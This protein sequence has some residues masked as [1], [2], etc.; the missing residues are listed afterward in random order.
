MTTPSSTIYVRPG[1]ASATWNYTNV[2]L[3]TGGGGAAV[4]AVA[5]DAS[6]L[7]N[8][9]FSRGDIQYSL[10]NGATWLTYALP[11]D[12]QGAYVNVAGTVWRFLD[13]VG[14]D[15]DRPD[16]FNVD[17]KLTNNSIVTVETTVFMDTQP[18]GVVGSNDV[19]FTTM[20]AG[21]VVDT[22]LPIDVGAT[23]GGRWVIDGQSQ[24][25]L[26]AIAY[27]PAIDAPAKLVI[28]NAAWMPAD[29]GAASVTVHYYDRYQIDSN[30]NPV[31]GTGAARTLT[32]AVEAGAGGSLPGFAAEARLGAAVDAVSGQPTLTALSGGGFVAV[33]Q[34]PD[35]VAGGAG[36]GLWAQLRDAG[37]NTL[38]AAFAITPDGDARIE[39]EPAVSALAGGRFVV[40]Y[41]VASGAAT[42]VAYRVIE[43]NGTAGAERVV[44]TG[45]AGDAAMPTLAT[46]ADGSF[47]VGWRSGAAVHVQAVDAAG[48]PAGAQQVYGALGS[49]YSP[50]LA[51]L[52][53]GGYI[54][55]WGEINDGNVYA[56]T[57]RAPAAVF[58]ASGDGY[59]ASITTAAPLPHV[60]A[61]AGGGFVVAWDSYANDPRGFSISDIFFQ[62]YDA[63]G[64]AVGAVVQANVDSGGGRFDA[65]VTALSSGGFLV[66][67]QGNDDDG[68]G[69]YG[70]RFGADGTALDS[71]EF[72][73]NGLRAGDQSSPDVI[74]LAGGGFAGAWVE[75]SASGAVS[76]EARVLPGVA[77]ASAV[78]GAQSASVGHAVDG[79]GSALTSGAADTGAAS[80]GVAADAAHTSGG[81]VT[82][83]GATP[84]TTTSGAAAVGAG[85]VAGSAAGS[86]SSS[87]ASSHVALP[88]KTI[89]FGSDGHALAAVGG[90]SK[91]VGSA[92]LDTL[93]YAGAR[94]G[95]HIAE[96]GGGT[97]AVTDAG[98]NHALLSG[99]ERLHFSDG[100][101]ALDID[102]AAGQAYR[103]YQ[104]AFDRT[105]D[106]AGLGYWI[107]ALDAGASLA[108][109]A[110]GFVASAEFAQLY[111]VHASDSQFVHALYQNV[112][113]RTA[114]GAGY[115]FWM[116]SL[117]TV[118]RADVLAD[119]SASAE[120][121]AQVI[122]SIQN[123]IQYLDW[124]A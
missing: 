109:A 68:N 27:D 79:A 74:A 29:G 15:T 103:L 16:T 24:N 119:F 19:V 61:L 123:G 91:V 54:V 124:H 66:A 102:G 22:L 82:S 39:G 57:S 110:S 28:A 8:Q 96:Q 23:T 60:A 72:S 117:Q 65:A 63:A 83:A 44:D 77:G 51:P 114:E 78:A 76:I 95:V 84:V 121:Q 53:G 36:A 67:W 56:A 112:L 1:W 40:A 4:T 81:T 9:Q 33:W 101:V 59:A 2:T 49:A 30:G 50:D 116:A 43:A 13:R 10:N 106:Q 118:T 64:N 48:V 98:G 52:V 87:A 85:S 7:L 42:T 99:V 58:I 88:I 107:A 94:A 86:T 75:T 90:E 47:V 18:V 46:L 80:G 5:F 34:A 31:A 32:Y 97:V 115:D 70:R 55:A 45:F 14:A 3:P 11:L 105:P 25:G 37:G 93:V 20:H 41:T 111:G 104:A 12:G 73:I 89:A 21:D 92:G 69:I 113:H 17:Y 35:T 38:G 108:Q 6:S 62:R 100:M 26:F 120:N 122:G 71:Q